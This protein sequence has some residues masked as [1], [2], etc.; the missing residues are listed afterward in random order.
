MVVAVRALAVALGRGE[1]ALVVALVLP[2]VGGPGA[3]VV[4][5]VREVLGGGLQALVGP[6]FVSALLGAAEVSSGGRGGGGGAK[7]RDKAIRSVTLPCAFLLKVPNTG[8]GGAFHFM[9]LYRK[10]YAFHT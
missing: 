4:A 2:P 5:L 8:Q 6:L 1:Q 9:L 7:T 10:H 3:L